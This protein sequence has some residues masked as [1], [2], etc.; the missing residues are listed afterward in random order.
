MT[1]KDFADV[2]IVIAGYPKEIN[3][4]LDSNSG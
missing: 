3:H 1:S 2:L 4:M